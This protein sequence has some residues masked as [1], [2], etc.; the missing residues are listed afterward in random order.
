MV[1]SKEACTRFYLVRANG[2]ARLNA[3]VSFMVW[4]LSAGIIKMFAAAVALPG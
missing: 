4:D 3:V 2:I 1:C